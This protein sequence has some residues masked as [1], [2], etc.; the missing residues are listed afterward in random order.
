[1]TLSATILDC[2]GIDLSAE[3]VALFRDVRPWGFTLFAR[4]VETPAQVQ[5]LCDALRDAGLPNVIV[6][7]SYVRSVLS[8]VILPHIKSQRGYHVAKARQLQ[9]AHH[10]IDRA[11]EVCFIAAIVSVTAYLLLE[12][13]ALTGIVPLGLP[14]SVAKTFTFLG[15]AFPTLGANL[16]GLRYFGDFDRFAAISHAT[17][18]QLAALE[19]RVELLLAS[20]PERLT[21][22]AASELVRNFEQIVVGE[23]E[24]WQAVFGSKHISLPA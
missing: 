22:G 12:L 11:A 24:G 10:R 21:Y 4:N 7:R 5:R 17:A 23:V 20:D 1:M 13:G 19:T 14:Y 8:G 9:T 3:E 16:A 15:V 6:D 2:T 18:S